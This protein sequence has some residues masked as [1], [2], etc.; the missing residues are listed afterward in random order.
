M[1]LLSKDINKQ[2]TSL[3]VVKAEFR[4]D[5][6]ILYLPQRLQ[7]LLKCDNGLWC[8]PHSPLLPNALP[9]VHAERSV[10]SPNLNS[11]QG[12]GMSAV[13][14]VCPHEYLL[15]WNVSGWLSGNLGI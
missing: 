3:L 15:D 5:F 13:I 12:T 9:P 6:S 10:Q 14:Q 8:G 4:R 7:Q 2:F 11:C 1:Y